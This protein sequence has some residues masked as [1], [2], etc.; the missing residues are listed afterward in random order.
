MKQVL[1]EIRTSTEMLPLLAEYE[2]QMDA[3]QQ[4]AYHLFHQRGATH[5]LALDD[6]LA[7]QSQTL[8]LPQAHASEDDTHYRILTS[9]SGFT[10]DRIRV[11]LSPDEMILRAEASSAARKNGKSFS[12]KAL[13]YCRFSG[14]I[15][16]ETATAGLTNGLLTVVVPKST[17]PAAL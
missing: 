1:I 17:S 4:R 6:W 12:L 10:A 11:V 16:L 5:G 9:L 2:E 8:C 7:A 3:V 14:P 13:T 15:Q